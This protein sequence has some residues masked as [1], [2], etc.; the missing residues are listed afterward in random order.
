MKP[1][2]RDAAPLP[3][4]GRV[5]YLIGPGFLLLAAWFLWG[6]PPSLLEP[7]QAAAFETTRLSTAP[8]RVSLGDPPVL[9]LNGY[10]RTCMDCHSLFPTRDVPREKRYQHESIRMDHGLNNTCRNCHDL[11][12][13]DLLVLHN[14][15]TLPFPESARLCGDCH[16]PTYRDWERGM[17]GRDQGFWDLKRGAMQRLRC[18]EC[19]D[20]HRPRSPA[21]DPLVPMPP[22]STLR[23]PHDR[24]PFH[25][26]ALP[27]DPLRSNLQGTR[28]ERETIPSPGEEEP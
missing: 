2:D 7:A 17:H 13:R 28:K 3:S 24:T 14:G 26:E 11:K 25:D 16:G 9:F 21:M 23:A 15:A 6:E 4:G 27:R 19:H 22:P 1:N 12:N 20:P 18:T 8:R 10:F 5:L